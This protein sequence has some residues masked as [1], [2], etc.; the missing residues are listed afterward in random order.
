MVV[1]RTFAACA[2]AVQTASRP[3]LLPPKPPAVRQLHASAISLKKQSKNQ[4][5]Q[6]FAEE[7]EEDEFDDDEVPPPSSNPSSTANTR[8]E[9]YDTYLAAVRSTLKQSQH[10][11]KTHHPSQREII[12]LV[13]QSSTETLPEVLEVVAKWRA[14][15]LQPISAKTAA[16]LARRLGE[17]AE[18]DG[19]KT[20]VEVLANRTK[21]GVDIPED[22]QPLYGLLAKISRPQALEAVTEAPV[23][24]ESEEG[25]APSGDSSVS[26]SSPSTADLAYSLYTTA[27]L[28]QPRA[29]T[30]DSLVLLATLSALA[31]NGELSSARASELV[32]VI[33]KEGE[34]AIVD[35]A[36]KLPRKWKDVARMRSRV[37]AQEMRNEKYAEDECWSRQQ[38]SEADL[39]Q[40]ND[41]QLS[42]LHGKI[43][44]I[45]GVTQDIYQDSREQNTLL[46]GTSNAMD[47]FKTSLSNTSQRFIRLMAPKRTADDA[48]KEDTKQQEEQEEQMQD[49]EEQEQDQESKKE[50][51]KT[52]RV[53]AVL[54]AEGYTGCA[55]IEELFSDGSYRNK[56]DKLLGITFGE[57][58]SPD[59]KQILEDY[60]VET[61]SIDEV[62]E[63][64]IKSLRIDTALIIPPARKDKLDQV[65]QF[66]E[67]AK[68]AKSV[69]NVVLLS[70]AGADY[71]DREK[72]P[73]LR[74]F[75]DLEVLAM[76]PKSDP[77]TEDT[78][79][80]PCVVRAGFYL[81]NL[82]H[83]SKQA[84]GEGKLPI[85][86]DED[87][88]F[89]PV[90][91]GDVAQLLAHIVT[92]RGE[93]G[94]S[95]DVRGQMIVLT[96]PQMTAG[97][98]LAEAASQALS[99]KLE[100]QSIK[101]SEAKKLLQSKHGEEIDEAELAYLLEY[102]S[103]VREGKTN[104]CAGRPVFKQLL[105]NDLTEPTEFFKAYSDSFSRKK[106][107]VT[108]TTKKVKE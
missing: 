25:A 24:E 53:I 101:E 30:S 15:G 31:R 46:D 40:G 51:G 12:R 73:H 28:H 104:Y 38:S 72:Q 98:E 82:L 33:Q 52:G 86:I 89:A 91:L 45:R 48:E 94:L 79:H 61:M 26:S 34:D 69:Q 36:T 105:G 49:E 35:H 37:I 54:S 96:G 65:K 108:K 27:L 90:A 70:S 17:A 63:E 99:T 39:E 9:R 19:G 16:V 64:K 92:S 55:V 66:L 76:Q 67:L 78:G 23:V 83:Y 93:H 71:A 106:R 2:R 87:H 42:A 56:F 47:S 13:Q 59:N 22:L 88:K 3:A 18:Q 81:E 10:Y 7:F 14:R 50:N 58:V 95:D 57:A 84:Q 1:A 62:D 85:P 75:I 77:S 103:L 74:E 100:F 4:A 97:P 20:G 43:S 5:V 44:A 102:Y 32:S 107:K 41:D 29:A 8:S 6:D 60:S 68:K 21:Y 80:S 11:H